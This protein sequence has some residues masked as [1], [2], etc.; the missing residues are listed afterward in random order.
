MSSS[1]ISE[2]K[3]LCISVN[4]VAEPTK[5]QP[6]TATF[7]GLMMVPIGYFLSIGFPD[8]MPQNA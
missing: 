5:P 3:R 7:F 4:A 8:S 1:A 2:N 6:I